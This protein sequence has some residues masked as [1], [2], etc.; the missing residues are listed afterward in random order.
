MTIVFNMK[1]VLLD[2][3][4]KSAP[5]NVTPLVMAVTMSMDCV[6]TV[7]IQ[8]GRECTVKHVMYQ[9]IIK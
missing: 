1:P 4:G 8:A 9:I 3:L 7:V 2:T 6:N 5:K